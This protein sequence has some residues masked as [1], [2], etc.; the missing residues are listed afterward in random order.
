MMNVGANAKVWLVLVLGM[1][2]RARTVFLQYLRKGLWKYFVQGSFCNYQMMYP[3]HDSLSGMVNLCRLNTL[4][5]NPIVRINLPLT[6][7][8]STAE[9]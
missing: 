9:D 5:R 3:A 7:T 1:G 8:N 4:G 2:T 6:I